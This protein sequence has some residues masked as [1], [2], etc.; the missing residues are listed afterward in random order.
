MEKT[1]KILNSKSLG[2][3]SKRMG[4]RV[5]EASMG[6]EVVFTKEDRK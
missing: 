2:T 4:N 5:Q 3:K 1:T 6:I